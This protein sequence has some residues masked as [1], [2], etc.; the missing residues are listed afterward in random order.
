MQ[1]LIL[2]FDHEGHEDTTSSDHCA[3]HEARFLQVLHALHGER[4]LPCLD[5]PMRALILQFDHEGHEGY[6]GYEENDRH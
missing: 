6:E 2:Q 4:L 3:M 1:A 5:I